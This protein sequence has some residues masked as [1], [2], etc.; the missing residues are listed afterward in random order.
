MELHPQRNK[1]KHIK[2][3]EMMFKIKLNRNTVC[4]IHW[5]A[6]KDGK[7]QTCCAEVVSKNK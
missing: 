1:T 3:S 2:K 6:F 5:A 7:L 4:H